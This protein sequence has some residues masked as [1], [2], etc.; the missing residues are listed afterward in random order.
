MKV[1]MVDPLVYPQ[2]DVQTWVEGTAEDVIDT[3]PAELAKIVAHAAETAHVFNWRRSMREVMGLQAMMVGGL[4][5][6]DE[7]IGQQYG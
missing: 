1:Y 6:V 5:P 4:I 7:A 2:G 3:V